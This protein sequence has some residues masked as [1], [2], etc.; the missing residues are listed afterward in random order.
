VVARRDKVDATD[1][2]HFA[3]ELPAVPTRV[4]AA[5]Y[6]VRE[7]ALAAEEGQR[8]RALLAVHRV[9]VDR[10]RRELQVDAEVERA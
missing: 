8:H 4:A 5:G 6:H 9:A 7:P 10:Q 3:A 1:P 2:S